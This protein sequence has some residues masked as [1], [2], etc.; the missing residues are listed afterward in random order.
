M[1]PEVQDYMALKTRL[2]S[3]L[4]ELGV[5][6]GMVLAVHSSTSGLGLRG[7]DARAV[8]DAML[9]AVG[10]EGTILFPTYTLQLTDPANA[11]A[12][13]VP[14]PE[15]P[16]SGETTAARD[17]RLR[18]ALPVFDAKTTPL[19]RERTGAVAQALWETDGAVRSTHPVLSM[20]AIG[21]K[22]A[23]LT[24]KGAGHGGFGKESPLE[25]V[26]QLEEGHILL[27]GVGH[28]KMANSSIHVSEY[29]VEFEGRRYDC[30]ALP[31]HKQ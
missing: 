1:K 26:S 6:R 16:R 28:E 20:G 7:G 5:R 22:A 21:P 29:R 19:W 3:K 13:P 10:P 30:P 4:R 24:E 31:S 2:V 14:E 27:L 25:R 17:A 8:A 18:A 12:W 15:A 23:W 9:E 11:H